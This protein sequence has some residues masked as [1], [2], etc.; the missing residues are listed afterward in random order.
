[1]E[2]RPVNSPELHAVALSKLWHQMVP[3]SVDH[4]LPL[5]PQHLRLLQ[6]VA[7]T[8]VFGLLGL[9]GELVKE[10]VNH[11]EQLAE[12]A[13]AYLKLTVVHVMVMQPKR[14]NVK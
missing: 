5:K 9:N 6:I 12:R 1:M 11:V 3:L 14:M 10:H 4:Y 13:L 7:P 2:L 8:A